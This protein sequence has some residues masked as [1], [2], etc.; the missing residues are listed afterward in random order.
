M[1]EKG[2]FTAGLDLGSATTKAVV[3]DADRKIVSMAIRPTGGVASE[4]G[5]KVLEEVL[6]K[7]GL[8]Y[9]DLLRLVTTGYGRRILRYPHVS[10]PEIICHAIGAHNLKS[11]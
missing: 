6:T 2:A 1:H 7:A 9:D 4:S 10:I 3:L 5:E 8:R 11:A